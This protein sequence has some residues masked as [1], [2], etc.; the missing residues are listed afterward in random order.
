V[1]DGVETLTALMPMVPMVP[2]GRPAM[3]PVTVSHRPVGRR[4]APSWSKSKTEKNAAHKQC[5]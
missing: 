3:V 4:G 2:P 1:L 5:A